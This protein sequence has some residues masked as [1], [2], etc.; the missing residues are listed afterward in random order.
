MPASFDP[1]R[2]LPLGLTLLL[3]LLLLSH[4]AVI[5]TLLELHHYFSISKNRDDP[6]QLFTTS[7][8][9]LYHLC[10]SW[11]G[12][13]WGLYRQCLRLESVRFLGIIKYTVAIIIRAYTSSNQHS[14]HAP[15][16]LDTPI[17]L[18]VYSEYRVI[19]VRRVLR[20]L[21]EYWWPK[22]SEYLEYEQY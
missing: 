1:R 9:A 6:K 17:I 10:S 8:L 15:S 18:G 16:I 20:V 7:K 3:L 19:F 13:F 4:D 2:F 12:G 21:V 11:F 14:T 5:G 22:Y